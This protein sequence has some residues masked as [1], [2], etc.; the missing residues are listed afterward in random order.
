LIERLNNINTNINTNT[1]Q[2]QHK[3]ITTPNATTMQRQESYSDEEG[4]S[5]IRHHKE[6]L[7]EASMDF[8]MNYG[9]SNSRYDFMWDYMR[10]E[11][12]GR[13]YFVSYF[14]WRFLNDTDDED[15]REAFDSL[16]M[17]ARW[18]IESEV[19][20]IDNHFHAAIIE[21]LKIPQLK[22]YHVDIK[23][24]WDNYVELV[25]L[26]GFNMA[27]DGSVTA[28]KKVPYDDY[29]YYNMQVKDHFSDAK[30][31]WSHDERV[32]KFLRKNTTYACENPFI[33]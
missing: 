21:M 10:E 30:E 4:L 18:A 6:L 7:L 23:Q 15:K 1:T 19:A 11:T 31:G 2:T 24:L 20:S 13:Y 26:L 28:I 27:E 8:I 17:F 29:T 12:D 9:G 25:K 3:P 16:A 33:C 22:S 32:E 5:R 14:I